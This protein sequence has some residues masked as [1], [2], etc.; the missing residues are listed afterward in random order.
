MLLRRL[1]R[2]VAIENALD[3]TIQIQ[4]LRYRDLVKQE[5]KRK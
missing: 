4:R 2:P 5:Q 1:N 3:Q